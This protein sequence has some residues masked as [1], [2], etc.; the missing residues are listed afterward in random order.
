M[1]RLMTCVVCFNIA[2]MHSANPY[3]VMRDVIFYFLRFFYFNIHWT[4]LYKGNKKKM[5]QGMSC[6]GKL[7]L[8]GK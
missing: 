4:W 2:Y 7:N 8:H 1:L 3:E 6:W 5:G